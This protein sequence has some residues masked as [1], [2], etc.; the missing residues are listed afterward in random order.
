ME[1]IRGLF[2][3]LTRCDEQIGNFDMEI[4]HLLLTTEIADQYHVDGLALH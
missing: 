3:E 4:L 1:V 2:S